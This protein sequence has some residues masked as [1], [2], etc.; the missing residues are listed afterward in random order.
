MVKCLSENEV[1]TILAVFY[2]LG[3][4]PYDKLNTFLGSVT[5]K[6]MNKLWGELNDWYQTKVLL[7]TFN[8][9]TGQY[10]D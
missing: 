9:E 3:K 5:I 10:E 2:E 1:R 8:E 7:K 6:E 4:M